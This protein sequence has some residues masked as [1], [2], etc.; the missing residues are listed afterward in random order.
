M[1]RIQKLETEQ[2]TTN[3]K[4]HEMEELVQQLLR[5]K[6]TPE[7]YVNLNLLKNSLTNENINYNSERVQKKEENPENKPQLIEE[8]ADFKQKII[9]QDKE[10]DYLRQ[11]ENKLM[12]LFFILHKRGIDVNAAYEEELKDVPTDRFN[13]WMKEHMG[14]EDPP[15]ISFDSKA[16][17]EDILTGPMPCPQKPE[18]VPVLELKWIPDYVTSSDEDE[19][20]ESSIFNMKKSLDGSK[21]QRPSELNSVLSLSFSQKDFSKEYR[22]D[23]SLNEDNKYNK[24]VVLNR[25][26]KH[27]NVDQRNLP[28]SQSLNT[29]KINFN[30]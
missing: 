10:I 4:Y 8:V 25:K 2:E 9:N 1:Q 17:Y 19:N 30:M 23:L 20:N 13:E 12:Y 28:M 3:K 5:K 26:I 18:I 7:S 16:S 6:S 22:E 11:K 14:E 29:D 15:D 27:T 24:E 21:L